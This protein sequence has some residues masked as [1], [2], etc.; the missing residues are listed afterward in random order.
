MSLGEYKKTVRM[1]TSHRGS[2]LDSFSTP[3][4]V[5]TKATNPLKRK[6]IKQ[7]YNTHN[8]QKVV[9]VFNET[10]YNAVCNFI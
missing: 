10:N 5:K 4:D 2:Y 7:S 3:V 9:E 6:S 1:A 8:F